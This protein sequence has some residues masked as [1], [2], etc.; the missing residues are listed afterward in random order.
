VSTAFDLGVVGADG[1]RLRTFPGPGVSNAY[2]FAWVP[3]AR[4]IVYARGA[5][6]VRTRDGWRDT[7]SCGPGRDSVWAD[8][9]DRV[10]RDCEIV[11]R[12]R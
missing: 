8:R 10:S 1:S 5:T 4:A 7:A 6:L 11:H 12:S 9:F 2:S 3:D